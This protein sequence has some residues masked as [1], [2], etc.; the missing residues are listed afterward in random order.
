MTCRGSWIGLDSPGR[1]LI[2]SDGQILD[3]WI[4]GGRRFLP[5]SQAKRTVKISDSQQCTVSLRVVAVLG[6]GE[7]LFL[8]SCGC[9]DEAHSSANVNGSSSTAV[10]NQFLVRCGAKSRERHGGKRWSGPSFFG[11]DRTDISDKIA[12]ALALPP[13][14]ASADPSTLLLRK[15]QMDLQPLNVHQ[16]RAQGRR[17][18]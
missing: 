6:K 5:G 11:F 8:C 15:R 13:V 2:R 1:R 18:I 7:A 17:L 14:Q 10:C 12:A 3:G 4:V 9:T 16:N